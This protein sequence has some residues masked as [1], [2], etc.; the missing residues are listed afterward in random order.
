MSSFVNAETFSFEALREEIGKISKST[1]KAD[2]MAGLQVALLTL[3][4]ALAYSLVAGLPLSCGLFAAI[5]SPL[6][7]ILFSSSRTLIAGPVNT[8]AIMIQMSIA[9]ILFTSFRDL[10]G[11]ER[12]MLAV[13]LVI[14]LAFM[15]GFFQVMISLFKLGRLTQFISYAVVL[16]Y[17]GGSLNAVVINQLYPFLGLTPDKEAVSL[18]DKLVDVITHFKGFDP[19]TAG[20][21]LV[22]FLSIIFLKRV[23]RK[24][25]AALITIC[26]ATIA[27]YFFQEVVMNDHFDAVKLVG[28][29]SERTSLVPEIYFPW[30]DFKMMNQ[31]L[32]IS[33]AIALLAML[34]TSC[35][36]K[37]IAAK[38]KE[39]ISVNQEIFSIGMGNIVSSLVGAMP[40]SVSPTRSGLN[41]DMGAR[42]R[43][44]GVFNVLFVAMLIS[45]F[46]FFVNSIPIATLSALIIITVFGLVNFRHCLICLKATKGDRWVLICTFLSCLFFS[47]DI[48][49]YIG[50]SLSITMYLKKAAVPQVVEYSVQ[51]N[52]ELK[53]INIHTQFQSK[54]VRVIKVEGELFFASAEVFE[55]T[56]KAIT[57]EDAGTKVIILQVKNARDIDATTCLT[58]IELNESLK[59]QGCHLLI[60]GLTHPVW[61]VLSY[62]GAV[63]NIGKDNLFL[64]DEKHPHRYLQ[65]ALEKA[66]LLLQT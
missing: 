9:D 34:E 10:S 55:N 53:A 58:L 30:L 25:P 24:L 3:P 51:E 41:A 52:G 38:T 2:L 64:F 8:I 26:F 22:S 42:T 60:A 23:N 5:F 1:L 27:I 20:V 40:I 7:A 50:V 43:M 48:A 66:N 31:L 44:A 57:D 46:A 47:L 15:V 36:S 17:L 63:D 61:D 65:K 59:K 49:F 11:G 29:S 45:L 6:I 37:L 16:G 4:Q 39:K 18:F 12:E 19:I 56:L 21:G 14:Q 13:Q 33:F 62:S 28:T 35:T 32:P 54:P